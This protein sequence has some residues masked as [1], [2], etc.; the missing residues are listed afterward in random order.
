MEQTRPLPINIDPPTAKGVYANGMLVS[1]SPEEFVL[2]FLAAFPP[3]GAL[4][5]RVIVSP[6]HLKRMIAV[7]QQNLKKYEEN[8]KKEVEPAEE[9]NTAPMGFDTRKQ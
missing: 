4:A 9:P 7:L 6:G 2:D 8:F 5:S 3:V 1:F